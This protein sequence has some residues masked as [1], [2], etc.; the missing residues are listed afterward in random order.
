MKR[1]KR[2]VLILT[3]FF[4][5]ISAC[6]TPYSNPSADFQE[7][8]LVGAWEARYSKQQVDKL[9]LRTDGTFKQI[10]QDN[11]KQDYSFETPWNEWWVER[12]SDG[13]LR[14][15]LQGA[16]YYL[17]GISIAEEEGVNREFWDPIGKEYIPMF[18]ELVLNI[19]MDKS[20]GLVLPH[21]W[22]SS[23]R[24]FALIGRHTEEFHRAKEP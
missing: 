17:A 2:L 20:G 14:I 9:V 5:A 1:N 21:M 12:L 4:L 10:Y 6:G 13:R 22:R 19:Q 18:R 23:D 7:S 16:R 15:H 11:I 24:G 8:D 3:I